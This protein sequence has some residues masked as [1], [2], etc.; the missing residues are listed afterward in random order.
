MEIDAFLADAAE[1]VNG[2]IYALGIGWNILQTMHLPTV[3]PRIALGITIHVPYT[4]TNQNH[5]LAVRL[6]DED[7][8]AIPLGEQPSAS[9]D[10]PPQRVMELGGD[11]NVGRPPLLPPGDEQVITLALNVNGMKFERPGLFTWSF[12]IDGTEV[13]RIPMRLIQ[14]AQAGPV[15]R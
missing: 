1:A 2:K 8:Q 4:A 9:P 7:G 5:K 14:I 3:H 13:K 10:E 11:F 15:G 12:A 6:E